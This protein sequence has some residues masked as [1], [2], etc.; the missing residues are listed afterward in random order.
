M[1]CVRH[2][3]PLFELENKDHTINPSAAS[4]SGGVCMNATGTASAIVLSRCSR[5][6]AHA[7]ASRPPKR[8]AAYAV[9]LACKVVTS[10][11]RPVEANAA[12]A[13]PIAAVTTGTPTTSTTAV[14]IAGTTVPR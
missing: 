11:G 1:E 10:S 13:E 8:A 9:R 5:D 12:R 3:R 2:F 4:P 7:K 14:V 6:V